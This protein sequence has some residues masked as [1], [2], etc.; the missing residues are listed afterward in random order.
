MNRICS[1]LPA[2]R[3][4]HLIDVE[5]LV[6]TTTYTEADVAVTAAAYGPVAA[7]GPTDLVVVSSSH[8]TALATWFGWPSARR[9][10]FGP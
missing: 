4:L 7:V 9:G 3:A 10:P 1:T 6:G 2:G 5:N 8:H